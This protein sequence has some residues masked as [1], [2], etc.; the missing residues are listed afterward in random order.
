MIISYILGTLGLAPVIVA[1]AQIIE[2]FAVIIEFFN[3]YS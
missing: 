1:L 2:P 3:M